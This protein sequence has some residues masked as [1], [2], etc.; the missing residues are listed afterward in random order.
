[1]K[2]NWIG[3]VYYTRSIIYSCILNE[4]ITNEYQLVVV[5]NDKTKPLFDNMSKKIVLVEVSATNKW[6]K[7]MHLL[8]IVKK[9]NVKWYYDIP[10]GKQGLL[11]KRIGIYWI[12]DF[13]HLHYPQFFDKVELDKRNEVFGAIA[14]GKNWLVLSSNACYED[15]RKAYPEHK[16]PVKIVHFVSCLVNEIVNITPELEYNTLNK[17]ELSKKYF[18]ISNLF[19]QHKNHIVIFEA[20]KKIVEESIFEDYEFVFTGELKD[21]RNLNYYNKLKSYIEDDRIKDKIKILG[22]IDRTEQLVVMK[23]AECLIQP[24]LFEGWGTVLEDAKVLGKKVVLSDIP[25]HHEQKN[26]NCFIFNPHDC[27]DLIEK[28]KEALDYC[29]KSYDGIKEAENNARSYSELLKEI[30]IG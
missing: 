24:S 21:Y 27:N 4:S 6:M 11:F 23:N 14:N 9:Y 22:F 18:Y 12:P 17:Y 26:D 1:M 13:Q 28:T 20:I 30:F 19:W 10:Q 29:I 5:V 16:C 15:F 3:G 2:E 7:L 8:A 25:V